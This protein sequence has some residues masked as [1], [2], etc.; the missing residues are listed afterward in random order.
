MDEAQLKV[1]GITAF[2]W[3]MDNQDKILHEIRNFMARKKDESV[4]RIR[5]LE[6]QN[7]KLDIEIAEQLKAQ[8][9]PL[10]DPLFN[11]PTVP[12]KPFDSMKDGIIIGPDLS[13]P[14]F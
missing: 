9:Y 3:I 1:I 11:T 2:S 7:R 6:L 8:T 10:R 12:Q 14:Q 13:G 5:N 4:L